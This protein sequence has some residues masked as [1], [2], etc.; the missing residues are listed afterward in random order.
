MFSGQNC[1]VILVHELIEGGGAVAGGE[2]GERVA[3]L[4]CGHCQSKCTGPRPATGAPNSLGIFGTKNS[5]IRQRADRGDRFDSGE[6]TAGAFAPTMPACEDEEASVEAS[7]PAF[8]WIGCWQAARS[9]S[10]KG[11]V[12]VAGFIG[13]LS[14]LTKESAMGSLAA[15][16]LSAC[17]RGWA[18]R[19][20]V[21]LHRLTVLA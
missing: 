9:A 5:A 10:S 20:T 15:G 19:R 3:N 2:A 8:A 7:R 13:L 18:E 4:I 16:R 17:A 14:G 21:R 11:R 1:R 12:G 6:M